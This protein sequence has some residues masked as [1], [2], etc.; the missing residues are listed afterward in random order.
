MASDHELPRLSSAELV[1][2]FGGDEVALR[3]YRMLAA[4]LREGRP[5]GEVARTFGVS[6]E[7]LRRLR[8]A[9]QREGLAAL[10]TR[11]R[12]G[13]HFARGSPLVKTI[14][15]ELSADP[16]VPANVLWRRVQ[17]RLRD[18]GFDAPRSTFYRLLARLRDEESAAA[19]ERAPLS[20]LRE[21]L[22]A[23]AENPPLAPGRSE[24]ATLL[25]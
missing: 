4:L 6:R 5:A 21:A 14:R 15:Q 24:L 1:A 7:S 25:P 17:S 9:F 3:R 22:G 23:L 16:G 11:K 8:L 12:G 20:R 19:G 13:G 2:R 10:Q 18:Q